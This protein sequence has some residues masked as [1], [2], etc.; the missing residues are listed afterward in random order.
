LTGKLSIIGSEI[1]EVNDHEQSKGRV[2]LKPG[3]TGLYQIN[4]KNA[5]ADM[6]CERYNLFYLKNYSLLL[7]IEI[8][9]KAI[10]K[11]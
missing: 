11:I 3:L 8:I 1:I 4:K 6:D 2:E 10:F 5:P 9:F 7:D